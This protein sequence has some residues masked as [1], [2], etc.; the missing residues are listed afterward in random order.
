MLSP[1][2]IAHL[3]QNAW[4]SKLPS[5]FKEFIVEHAVQQHFAKERAIFHSGDLFNGIYA[6]LEGAVRLGYILSLIHI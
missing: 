6:V 5:V 3:E 4:F 1:I 2:Y